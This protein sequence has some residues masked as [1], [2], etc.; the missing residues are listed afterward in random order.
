MISLYEW[1]LLRLLNETQ[2]LYECNI[3][4]GHDPF[5]AKN[6]CQVFYARNLSLAYI[7][8]FLFKQLFDNIYRVSSNNNFKMVIICEARSSYNVT[9]FLQHYVLLICW[10]KIQNA[11]KEFSREVSVFERLIILYGLNHLQQHLSDFYEGGF[12]TGPQFSV[13]IKS[14]IL[15]LCAEIKPE[16]VSLVDAIA[17]PDFILNSAI[18][19][20]NGEVSIWCKFLFFIFE[21]L[22]VILLLALTVFLL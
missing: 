19:K 6:N 10:K 20:S 5:T 8:V 4:S 16:A 17:P 21:E 7:E 15:K 12:T 14:A 13:I 18:G 1:L 2:K 11:D 22:T 9:L 3:K